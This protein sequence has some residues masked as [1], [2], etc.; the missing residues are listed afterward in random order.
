MTLRLDC[1]FSTRFP[2]RRFSTN[3]RRFSWVTAL[4]KKVIFPLMSP[5]REGV[6]CA[7]RWWAR[8]L[9]YPA[10]TTPIPTPEKAEQ[11]HV[12]QNS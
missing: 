5:S 8:R 4:W 10:W 3:C 2:G 9:S 1:T 11:L 6:L 12:T 7:P